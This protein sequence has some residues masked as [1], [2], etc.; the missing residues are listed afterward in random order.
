MKKQM[1]ASSLFLLTIL[2]LP[3][4]VSAA[5]FNYTPMEQIPG[6]STTGGFC[7]YISAVYKFGIWAVGIAAMLMIMIGGYMYMMSAGN[8]ASTGK[9]KS[10]IT[11]AIIGLIL[12]LTSYLILYEINPN[13]L[14]CK[15][16]AGDG[17]AATRTQ[18]AAQAPAG[19]AKPATGAGTC[20][21]LNSQVP[22]QCGDAS[23]QLQTMLSC[24]AE[25]LGNTVQISSISDGNG[26]LTCYSK[27]SL[28]CTGN[29]QTGCCFHSRSSCHY[30]GTCNDGSHAADFSA[31]GSS[32]SNTTIKNAIQNCGG[33]ALDEGNHVH[34][35]IGSCCNL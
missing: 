21:G 18:P 32:A 30:G 10:V 33:K 20:A 1:L 35:S 7:S 12:A 15:I 16:S 5:S 34:G 28:K 9:A 25:K 2:F 13:L 26:G 24:I 17:T 19:A 3:A 22:A 11:D 14:S 29:S 23:P 31:K 8:T 27:Y 4:F 6:F